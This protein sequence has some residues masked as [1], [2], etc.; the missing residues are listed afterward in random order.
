MMLFI[1]LFLAH[2]LGDFFF[3][4]QKWIA[5]AALHRWRS[6]YLYIHGC[7]HFLLTLMIS[8]NFGLLKTAC[9]ISV[10]HLLTEGIKLQFQR[11]AT[12]RTWFFITQ[13]IHIS[14]LLIAWLQFEKITWN[15]IELINSKFLLIVTAMLF[16]L[17]PASLLTKNA[18]AKWTPA[19]SGQPSA[20]AQS[21]KEAGEWIGFLERL[22]ILTFILLGKWE[23]VGFLLAAKSIFRFGDLKEPKETQLTEYVLIGTFLSFSIAILTGIL[24]HY[25]LNR[26]Q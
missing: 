5:S 11:P 8:W 20:V 14:V 12:Q 10:L 9:I 1:Q 19:I 6:P 3:H 4:Q 15:Y 24:T 22:M 18:I 21:L 17:K 26:I 23:G 25:L 2:L 16:V 7:M 13:S